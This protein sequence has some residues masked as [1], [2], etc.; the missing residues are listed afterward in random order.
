ML[1][2]RHPVN[3]YIYLCVCVNEARITFRLSVCLSVFPSVC[4]S[5]RPSVF[6][7]DRRSVRPSVRPSPLSVR[8]SENYRSEI[9]ITWY[10]YGVMVL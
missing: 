3:K 9:D 7:S 8:P 5:V 6:L 4:L 2:N 10:E 1:F